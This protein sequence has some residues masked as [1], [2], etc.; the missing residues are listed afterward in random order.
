NPGGPL[1]VSWPLLGVPG[2][3]VAGAVIDHVEVGIVVGPSPHAAAADLPGLRRPGLHAQIRAA[4]G[5]VGGLEVL[6]NQ[7][8]RVWT[9]AVGF[10]QELAATFI[11]CAQ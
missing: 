8:F 1:V 4:V 6:P 5:R 10:P 11:E 3:G 2:T 7:Y 9:R